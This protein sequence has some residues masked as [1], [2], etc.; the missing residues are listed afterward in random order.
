MTDSMSSRLEAAKD[1]VRFSSSSFS[2]SAVLSLSLSISL[3]LSLIHIQQAQQRP[4]FMYYISDMLLPLF[5][6]FLCILSFFLLATFTIDD[7]DRSISKFK[8]SNDLATNDAFF[9]HFGRFFLNFFTIQIA[10]LKIQIEQAQ[11]QKT[12][13][14]MAQA[15]QKVLQ[16]TA[17]SAATAPNAAPADD[18]IG[19]SDHNTKS[20]ARPPATLRTPPSIKVRR[21]L[22]G[23]FGKITAIHWDGTSTQVVSAGQDGNLLIWNAVTA[24]KAQAIPL[25][26]SYVMACGMEP[27]RGNLVASGGLDNMCTVYS[28]NGTFAHHPLD[29][30]TTHAVELASHDGFLS[31]CRFTS[32]QEIITSSGD[33]TCIQ[34]DISAAKPVSTFAEHAADAMYLSL[35]PNDKH[36]FASCSVDQT[37]KVWDTR[38]GGGSN[39][40]SAGQKKAVQTFGGFHS[41]DINCIEFMPGNG[42][43][44][45]TCSQDSTVRL[46]DLRAYNQV[47]KF[48]VTPTTAA[49]MAAAAA[50]AEGGG[51]GVEGV[52]GGGGMGGGGGNLGG[53]K[54][55]NVAAPPA[56]VPASHGEVGDGDD[57]ESGDDNVMDGGRPNP[58]RAAA[59]QDFEE[60]VGYDAFTSLAFS[61]SGRLIFC[62]HANGSIYAFDVLSSDASGSGSGGG[63]ATFVLQDAHE[64][65][66]SSIG[67]SPSGNALA[68]ASWDS[69]LK[70]WA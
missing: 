3:H 48:S 63:D 23:H 16:A 31:C 13:Q 21:T 15:L 39:S 42:N 5:R 1:K 11:K 20:V 50:T 29:V 28:V 57:A 7:D 67:V 8:I 27:T 18:D 69:S 43:A 46:F 32:E 19:G 4:P 65:N 62:G 70:I 60:E 56:V 37:V 6:F 24:N 55:T 68:T 26:S 49:M 61:G 38:V 35:K 47:A 22:K 41:G 33:S 54:P 40:G 59:M 10:S 34:W 44:F 30:A 36:V 51:D 66:V 53:N 14:T 58:A 12:D 64:R 17:A 45:A 25:K 2:S 52:G 9:R